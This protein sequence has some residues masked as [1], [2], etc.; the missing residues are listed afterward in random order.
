MSALSG[1][2]AICGYMGR[3]ESTMLTIIRDL[4]FPAKKICG[5]WESDTELA[6]KWRVG[7]ISGPAAFP[8]PA[9][10]IKKAKQQVAR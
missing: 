8:A 6:D 3:S 7:Q 1:M 10:P 9:R 5:I 4:D 2:K